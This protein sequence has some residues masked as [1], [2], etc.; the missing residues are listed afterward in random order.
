VPLAVTNGAVPVAFPA[1]T[2]PVAKFTVDPPVFAPGDRV[3][4]TAAPSPHTKFTWFFGDG[5]RA[6]GHRVR[7]RFKDA[8]GTELDGAN[9]AGRFRV[10]LRAE[11][12]ERRQD[13]AAEGVVAVARWHDAVTPQGAVKPGLAWKVYPGSW[14]QLPDLS[15]RTPVFSGV[16]P[17]IQA[18]SRGFTR[19]AVAWDGF[20][21]IPADGGYTFHLM[22]RDGARLVIDGMEVART[23]P[24]FAQVCGS[25]GN[26]LRY[27]LASLG[28]RAGPHRFHL[29][30]LHQV[31]RGTPR[32]LWE[33][34]RL[35]LNDIPA[36][37]FSH[38]P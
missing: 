36:A 35:R 23:G 22:A 33:G 28:L 17:G 18:D 7:H 37:A 26:A 21:N 29:E 2:G 6:R 12:N 14:T 1:P 10:M 32:L 19:Y 15:T 20:I 38:A 5:A 30:S 34:P 16:S 24:P 27:T 25:P 8:E 9:G 4:F 31:S 3:T 13:W 11:D